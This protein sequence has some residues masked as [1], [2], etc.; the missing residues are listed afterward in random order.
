MNKWIDVNKKL[1]ENYTEV[2]Y[3]SVNDSGTTEIMTGHREHAYWTH[4]CS[5]YSTRILNENV[6]VTHWMPLPSAP[7]NK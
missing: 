3:F 2:L 4:C 6:R 1:P 5:F 7:E